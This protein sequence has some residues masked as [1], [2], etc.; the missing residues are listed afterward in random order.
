MHS[1]P[2]PQ[3]RFYSGIQS[4]ETYS[5]E[6]FLLY[7]EIDLFLE[8]PFYIEASSNQYIFKL[9]EAIQH[10]SGYRLDQQRL[11]L[12]KYMSTCWSK[13]L[14]DGGKLGDYGVFENNMHDYQLFVT[15]RNINRHMNFTATPNVTHYEYA[16]MSY[17]VYEPSGQ[18]LDGW[19]VTVYNPPNKNDLVLAAYVNVARHQCVISIRGT[20]LTGSVF[21]N[22]LTDLRLFFTNQAIDIYDAARAEVHD[23]LI[24][25]P[26]LGPTSYDISFTGHSLGAALAESF[27]CT[28]QA[29][30]VTFDS[31]GTERILNNDPD[32]QKNIRNGYQ[33]QERIR[34]YL[35]TYANIINVANPQSGN[36][37]KEQSIKGTLWP[38]FFEHLTEHASQ[39]FLL[40]LLL[41]QSMKPVAFHLLPPEIP[42]RIRLNIILT[43]KLLQ[44][45]IHVE[46]CPLS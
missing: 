11:H 19:N 34:T 20:V 23:A 4:D 21:Y 18:F 36:A 14:K 40:C 3:L 1:P 22:L 17:H 15:K 37:Y 27:A 46:K 32:C 28:Y 25:I 12:C 41:I 13:K 6:T 2:G 30:A 33:P 31:P 43:N 16:M 10:R 39:Q 26:G 44:L 9:K 7:V 42:K 8:P 35:G 24:S 45:S 29:Y 5:N 38:T